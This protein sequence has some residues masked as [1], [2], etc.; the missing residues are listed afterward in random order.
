MLFSFNNGAYSIG[1]AGMSILFE[2]MTSFLSITFWTI[3]CFSVAALT[4]NLVAG[5]LTY[6]ILPILSLPLS[7]IG[8]DLV[9]I[10]NVFNWS[11]FIGETVPGPI[12]SNFFISF[13]MT[14]IYVGGLLG[15]CY[16][17]VNKRD[18]A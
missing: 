1:P 4:K 11:S 10:S 8:L 9:F 13:A 2:M 18:L 16:Y 12:G 7:F 17:V 15:A 6:A 14:I 3:T 5:I